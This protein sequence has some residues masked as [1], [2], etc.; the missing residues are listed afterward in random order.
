MKKYNILAMFLTFVLILPF[1]LVGAQSSSINL[2]EQGVYHE[3]GSY[4]FSS[5]ELERLNELEYQ[6]LSNGETMDFFTVLTQ[7]S[8]TYVSN[9]TQEQKNSMKMVDYNVNS[10]KINSIGQA[11]EIS[12]SASAEGIWYRTYIDISRYGASLK[13]YGSLTRNMNGPTDPAFQWASVVTEIYNS[14]TGGRVTYSVNTVAWPPNSTLFVSA[15]A[16]ADPTSGR[17][18]AYGT[19]MFPTTDV[20]GRDY[21]VDP[22]VK[23]PTI[24]YTHPY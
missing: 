23:S 15:T 1:Q 13:G 20:L 11:D 16:I 3:D 21:F 17:Y 2:Q 22:S 14:N 7:V 19:Y 24:S 4:Q 18:H 9:L 6:L 8:P 12:P 10:G 5:V